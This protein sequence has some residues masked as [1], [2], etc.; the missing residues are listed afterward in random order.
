MFYKGFRRLVLSQQQLTFYFKTKLANSVECFTT[1]HLLLVSDCYW[2][3][4]SNPK[5]TMSLFG[6]M[7]FSDKPAYGFQQKHESNRKA[8]SWDLFR[9]RIRKK[10]V[11]ALPGDP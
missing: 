8:L 4:N 9:K 7:V 1:L 10:T 5:A 2:K 6:L 3:L 11:I